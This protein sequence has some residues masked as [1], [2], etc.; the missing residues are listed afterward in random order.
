MADVSSAMFGGDLEDFASSGL[1]KSLLIH[2]ELLELIEDQSFD[3]QYA[4]RPHGQ[5][6]AAHRAGATG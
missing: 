6:H 5:V 4:W 2:V 3:P 1:Q